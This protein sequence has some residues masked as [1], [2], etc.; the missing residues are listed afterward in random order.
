[1]DTVR[2]FK[3]RAK[4]QL[5]SARAGTAHPPTLQQMQH[6]VAREAG[7]RSWRDLLHADED[8]RQLAV[9]MTLEPHLN[10]NGFGPGAY[11]GTMD[12]R[13]ARM[14]GWR[15]ELRGRARDVARVRDWLL[16]N[17]APRKTVNPNVGSY[18][19]KHLVE[20]A[21]GTYIENGVLIAAAIGAGYGY[22][23]EPG[24][25]PNATLAM[26]SVSVKQLRNRM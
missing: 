6:E 22:R 21:M 1:M 3:D 5:R 20:R 16:A 15:R 24:W 8:D 2:F 7:Y 18:S 13:R 25:S 11:G 12:E 26:S 17:V 14:A 4:A 10:L 19:L 9:T 23:R